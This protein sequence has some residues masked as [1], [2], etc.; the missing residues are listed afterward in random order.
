[1]V[2]HASA[3]LRRHISGGDVLETGDSNLA[4]LDVINIAV[5]LMAR[6]Q[7]SVFQ[8]RDMTDVDQILDMGSTSIF[9]TRRSDSVLGNARSASRSCFS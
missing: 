3:L 2:W 4:V 6:Y 5:R 9:L 1:M 7:P 8:W